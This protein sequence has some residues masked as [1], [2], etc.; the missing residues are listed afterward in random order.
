M[1]Q[2]NIVGKSYY[3]L[4]GEHPPFFGKSSVVL[5]GNEFM[6][7]VFPKQY[8]IIAKEKSFVHFLKSIKKG[9][10]GGLAKFIEKN[11]KVRILVGE[12]EMANVMMYFTSQLQ[13]VFGLSDMDALLIL[14]K[15]RERYFMDYRSLLRI[16]SGIYADFKKSKDYAI[17]KKDI[18]Y[19]KDKVSELPLEIAYMLYARN[20]DDGSAIKTK[21]EGLRPYF[22]DRILSML[23]HHSIRSLMSYPRVIE[24]FLGTKISEH[25][26]LG[27][28]EGNKFLHEIYL[29]RDGHEK[30]MAFYKKHE[31]NIKK[32]VKCILEVDELDGEAD[33]LEKEIGRLETHFKEG[34]DLKELLNH[35]SEAFFSEYLFTDDNRKV[36]VHLIRALADERRQLEK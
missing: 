9:K 14:Q 32:L 21:L 8:K 29:G 16:S 34:S 30:S 33:I 18:V 7:V 12:E 20:V 11:P 1:Q 13:E 23:S 26:L 17:D 15:Q 4:G 28:I 27:A 6:E 35:N 5:L 25:D 31:K 19:S 3:T 22:Y 36:N 2:F 10:N 24:K